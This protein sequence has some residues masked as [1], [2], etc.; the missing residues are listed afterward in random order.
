MKMTDFTKCIQAYYGPYDNDFVLRTVMLYLKEYEDMD[1]DGLFE[2][3]LRQFSKRWGKTPDIAVFEEVSKDS[4]KTEIYQHRVRWGVITQSGNG[5]FWEDK[6][7]ELEADDFPITSHFL[8][9]IEKGQIGEN[10]KERQI[11]K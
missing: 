1:L 4:F 2:C 5:N 3:T 10:G 9:L 7:R 6:E 11:T 8:K